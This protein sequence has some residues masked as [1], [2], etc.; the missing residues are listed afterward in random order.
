VG[1][2]APAIYLSGQNS[3]HLGWIPPRHWECRYFD[4]IPAIEGLANHARFGK[5]SVRSM[6]LPTIRMFAA[7]ISANFSKNYKMMKHPYPM[8]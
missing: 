2:A 8:R 1:Y 5:A 4:P 7:P 6:K 3:G